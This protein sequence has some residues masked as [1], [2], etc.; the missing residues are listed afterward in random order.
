MKIF[1]ISC[2]AFAL[3]LGGCA[4]QAAAPAQPSPT[5]VVPATAAPTQTTAPEPSPATTAAG[6]K[7]SAYEIE[8]KLVQLVDGVS[9]EEAAPGS[10]TKIITRHFG[11]EA[12]GDLNGDGQED[13]VFLLTQDPG[14]SGTFFYVVAA[15]KNNDG[16][17]G[18]NAILLGD[19]IAPQTTQIEDG[20][21]IVNYADRKPDEPLTADPSVGVSKYLKLVDGRLV[22]ENAASPLT[23][24]KWT[25]LKTQM[26]DDSVTTPVQPDA[27]T[28]E[29]HED[30]TVSGTTDCNS[31]S[32]TYT[33]NASAISFGPFASTMMACEG[34]QE[35]EYMQM[36]GEVDHYLIQDSQLVLLIKY[37]S[38][39]MIYQ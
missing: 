2:L 20:R 31:F 18:S 32:G 19:R 1:L 15:L 33:V 17:T 7:D 6:Y 28:L 22:E 27:F 3:I 29:F 24:Q 21:I 16:Y 26:N 38:G 30:G 35:S 25:W 11:N 4:P 10:A 37:D 9:E 14:G 23:S 5:A 12:F 39:S 13:V 8:G 34:S 36:L